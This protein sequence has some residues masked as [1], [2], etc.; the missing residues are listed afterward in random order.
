ME[1]SRLEHWTQLHTESPGNVKGAGS[2][3]KGRRA[4]TGGKDW[5][6]VSEASP[7]FYRLL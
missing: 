2:L 1:K 7:T 5:E 4:H 3:R 6:G